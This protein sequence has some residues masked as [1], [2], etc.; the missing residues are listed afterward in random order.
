MTA[1]H[2]IV[3]GA[4]AGGLAAGIDLARAGF[5]VTM[6]ERAAT[7]GGKMHTREVDDRQVDGGPTVLT[8]RSIFE[9]LF[10]D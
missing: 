2:A 1:R 3:V 6:L 7:P 5:R 4:G 10:A 9:Q 8:M